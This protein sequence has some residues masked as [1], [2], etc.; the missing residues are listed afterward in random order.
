MIVRDDYLMRDLSYL[1]EGLGVLLKSCILVSLFS[2]I[3]L[4]NNTKKAEIE[5]IITNYERNEL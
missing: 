3:D 4:E 2:M 1:V 5:R